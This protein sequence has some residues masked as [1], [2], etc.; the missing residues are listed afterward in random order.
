MLGGHVPS[1]RAK[2]EFGIEACG[3]ATIGMAATAAVVAVGTPESEDVFLREVH[4]R[5][6]PGVAVTA[7]S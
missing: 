1:A 6:V 5:V 4:A 2:R 7:I 3:P